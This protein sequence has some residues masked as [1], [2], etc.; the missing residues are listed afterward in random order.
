V[1]YVRDRLDR[2]LRQQG[3]DERSVAD[4]RRVLDPNVL[5]LGFAR[6]FT[7]YKRPD[8]LLHD[9]ARLIAILTHP[10]RPCQ[11]VIAGK[12]HPDDEGGKAMVQRWARFARSD[13]VRARVVFLED[14]DMVLA[15]QLAGGV[16]V[17]INTP[18]RPA[19]ACG[20]SGMKMLVN[21]G[22]NCSML[23]GWWDEA[24]DPAV[25]WAIGGRDDHDGSADGDDAQSLYALL[26]GQIAPMFYARDAHGVPAE[27]VEKVRNSMTR[28]AAEFSSDRMLRQYVE[29]AY[30]PAASDYLA[31][32]QGRG[33]LAAELEAWVTDIADGWAT[34]RLGHLE[35]TGIDGAWDLRLEAFLGD[36]DRGSVHLEVYA[37][38]GPDR[39]ARLEPMRWSEA[40][41]GVVN[42][43]VYRCSVPAD[44]AAEHYTP[45]VV[46]FHTAALLPIESR[47]ITWWTPSSGRVVHAAASE[48]A[49]A[50]PS[51]ALETLVVASE[52]LE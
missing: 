30:L 20:T 16:D 21:G 40:L 52:G 1:T 6:R 5:T 26:E 4:A 39:P 36:I 28:L 14:Y 38:A 44:R 43:H 51:G 23:D 17:W 15:Q 13:E 8:L 10:E 35:V 19:E 37:E 11:L 34:I 9:P 45:R 27:W 33:R 41:V 46:P 32:A 2:Q 18:R 22:L 24:Y 50:Q 49:D 42:G 29:E 47:Q 3:V 48:P 12:A 31:R 7:G 25:G